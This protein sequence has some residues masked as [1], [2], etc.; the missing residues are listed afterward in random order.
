[1]K[2]SLKH[3]DSW[4]SCGRVRCI[5]RPHLNRPPTQRI[6]TEKD[7]SENSKSISHPTNSIFQWPERFPICSWMQKKVWI[8]ISSFGKCRAAAAVK[9]MFSFT[10]LMKTTLKPSKTFLPLQISEGQHWWRNRRKFKS[11]SNVE[12]IYK[13]LHVFKFG[14]NNLWTQG[15]MRPSAAGPRD[16]PRAIYRASWCKIPAPGKSLGPRGVYFPIHPSSRQCT[17]TIHF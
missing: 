7:F 4:K 5:I 17:D 6:P 8:F 1:M 9:D 10:F 14:R 12:E 2:G 3:W 11:S 16:C 15:S 13:N